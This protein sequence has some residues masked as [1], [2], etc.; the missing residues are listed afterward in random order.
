MT[1]IGL[2]E[3]LANPSPPA[4]PANERNVQARMTESQPGMHPFEVTDPGDSISADN[5]GFLLRELT[6]S[7]W[8][9]LFL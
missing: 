4:D 8:I 6:I 3:T 7:S 9:N 2:R 5:P 1:A